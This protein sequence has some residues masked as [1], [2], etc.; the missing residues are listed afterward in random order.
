M[1]QYDGFRCGFTMHPGL[2]DRDLPHEQTV[3]LDI[4]LRNCAKHRESESLGPAIDSK[5][6]EAR[7][8]LGT[9]EE[10]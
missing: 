8:Y 6:D 5:P 10:R 7:E 4:S 1:W 3:D 9:A 2:L